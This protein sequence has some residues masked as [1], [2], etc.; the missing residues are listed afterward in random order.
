[1][2]LVLDASVVLRLLLHTGASG[3]DTS[4]AVAGHDLHAPH[5]LDVEVTS[6]LR[7]LVT[8]RAMTLPRAAA[9]LDDLATLRLDRYPHLPLLP[10][11]WALRANLSAYDAAYAALAE[12]LE[13]PLLTSDPGLATA[14]GPRCA[15]QHLP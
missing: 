1:V 3:S 12:T 14:R 9:A 5:L 15:R 7:R 2:S 4:A 10:R 11:I 6:A 8:S 13:C